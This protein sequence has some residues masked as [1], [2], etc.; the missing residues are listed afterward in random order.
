MSSYKYSHSWTQVRELSKFIED[1]PVLPPF[2]AT[3]EYMQ[4]DLRQPPTIKEA[5][6]LHLTLTALFLCPPRFT[7]P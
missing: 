6:L 7:Y 4:A 5:R 2:C 3:L 1:I